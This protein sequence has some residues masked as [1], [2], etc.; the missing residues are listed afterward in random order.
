MTSKCFLF[1]LPD[2]HLLSDLELNMKPRTTSDF[3]LVGEFEKLVLMSQCHRTVSSKRAHLGLRCIPT[4]S[5]ALAR[6]Y[7]PVPF[8]SFRLM[9][10]TQEKSTVRQSLS[11]NVS[12]AIR[13]TGRGSRRDLYS[14]RQSILTKARS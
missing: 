12:N 13:N 1:L 2:V 6:F 8:F 9:P 3:R 14:P 5:N 4:H 10:F 11:L 7:P